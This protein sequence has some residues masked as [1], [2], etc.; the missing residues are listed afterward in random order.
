MLPLWQIHSDWDFVAKH[1]TLAEH[2]SSRFIFTRW[3]VWAYRLR[4]RYFSND[5]DRRSP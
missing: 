1:A 2:F 3:P 4:M 5:A